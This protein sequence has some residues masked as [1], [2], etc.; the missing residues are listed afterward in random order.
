VP[1]GSDKKYATI[2]PSGATARNRGGA[3]K[4]GYPIVPKGLPLQAL[5]DGRINTVM[6][7]ELPAEKAVVWTKP[8]DWV[9]DAKKPKQGL[10]GLRTFA[11]A[12]LADGSVHRLSSAASAET[13][14]RALGRADGET[15]EHEKVFTPA[16][17]PD[18]NGA[19]KTSPDR[20]RF[21]DPKKES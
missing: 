14:L 4:D 2:F 5:I 20:P 13:L 8:D 12:T 18:R 9:V 3:L 15:F 17:R 11:L 16:K 1:L 19:T 10:F 7:V 21:D 6:I